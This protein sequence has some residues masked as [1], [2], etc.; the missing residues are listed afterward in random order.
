MPFLGRLIYVVGR[1]TSGAAVANADVEVRFPG[2]TKL[3]DQTLALPNTFNVNHR[4]AVRTGDS[5]RIGNGEGTSYTVTATTRTSITLSGSGSLAVLDDE[6]FTI[7][8][9]LPTLY[10]DNMRAEV[11]TN[12]LVTDSQGEIRAWCSPGPY[13]LFIRKPGEITPRLIE[14]YIIHSDD[15]A[16]YLDD[17]RWGLVLDGVAND[18]PALNALIAEMFDTIPIGTGVTGLKAGKI[19]A[20]PC[21][22]LTNEQ[23]IQKTRVHMIGAGARSSRILAGPSFPE[24]AGSA[25]A[26]IRIGD[27]A[28]GDNY[29]SIMEG[30]QLDGN[31]R[32]GLTGFYSTNIQE[33][34]G[35]RDVEI[36]RVNRGVWF[37][38]F[39]CQN[40]SLKRVN[41]L[42]SPGDTTGY[43]YYLDSTASRATVEDCTVVTYDGVTQCSTPAFYVNIGHVW[44]RDIHVERHDVGIE[45]AG[46]GTGG[47][48]QFYPSTAGTVPIGI[49]IG[50]GSKGVDIRDA[51]GDVAGFSVQDDNTGKTFYMNG[52][53]YYVHTNDGDGG[54]DRTIL[55]STSGSPSRTFSPTQFRTNLRYKNRT[56]IASGSIT[57]FLPTGNYLRVTG[58]TPFSSIFHG[59]GD[60][61]GDQGRLIVVEF[62]NAVSNFVTSGGNITLQ[63]GGGSFSTAAGSL[64]ILIGNS[65]GWTEVYRSGVFGGLQSVSVTAGSGALSPDGS[66]VVEVTKASGAGDFTYTSI[67]NASLYKGRT[68]TIIVQKTDTND[69]LVINDSASCK[70]QNN[71]NFSVGPTQDQAG[72]LTL[73]SNGNEFYEVARQN[74]L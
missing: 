64:M 26:I 8:S 9:R 71:A 3:G 20:G 28:D 59:A 24:S 50:A 70:L 15:G 33:G 45:F 7:I 4:G 62:Q 41:V 72:T 29:Q 18:G 56:D 39:G 2:A 5:V 37:S 22:L 68:L 48:E 54:T 74:I 25:S 10:Y 51:V 12:P 21:N 69:N 35:P 27:P 31:G 46:L 14:D 44:F 40:W 32:A 66:S 65:A 55:S 52:G 30:W 1:D 42:T 23:I 13:D 67:S 61:D 6:R 16:W 63:P 73:I 36:N 58:T 11:K 57:G 53:G 47:V 34:S 38:G 17:P 60:F 49:K 43:G 19:I